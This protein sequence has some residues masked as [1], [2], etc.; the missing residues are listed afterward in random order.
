M[1]RDVSKRTTKSVE[2]QHCHPIAYSN[3]GKDYRISV[4]CFNQTNDFLALGND[5]DHPA[6]HEC[7]GPVLL[8]DGKIG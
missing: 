6:R 3:D 2:Y 8:G 4:L 7:Y 1:P 5:G